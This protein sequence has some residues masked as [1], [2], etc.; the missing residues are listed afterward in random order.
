MVWRDYQV[1]DLR[2][3]VRTNSCGFADWLDYALPE[4]LIEEETQPVYSVY[5]GGMEPRGV[6]RRFHV[7]Y[8]GTLPAARTLS[9][10]TVGRTLLAEM[11]SWIHGRR[12][13][14]VYLGASLAASNG[15]IALIPSGLAHDLGGLG[16][17][18]ER[19]GI[20]LAA[21]PSVAV[22]FASGLVRPPQRILDVPPDA[23]DALD[24]HV[25]GSVPD[26][27]MTIPEPRRPDV[28]LLSRHAP[29]PAVRPVSRAAALHGLAATSPNL[30]AAGGPGLQALGRLVAAADCFLVEGPDAESR[31]DAL[32][33]VLNA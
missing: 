4:Y 7:L 22:D 24:G 20:R 9:I 31:L 13:D 29:E 10:R 18:L 21:E 27:R 32:A 26:D 25:P 2:L 1:G 5:V 30:H 15:S 23:L 14:A 19:A 12:D 11:E 28:I 33:P 17:R 16:R 8:R 3:G 6:G